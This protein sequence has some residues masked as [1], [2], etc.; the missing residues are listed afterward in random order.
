MS[1]TISRRE[2]LHD[3]LA[4]GLVLGAGWPALAQGE[5]LIPFTDLPTPGPNA[6]VPPNL[7]NYFTDNDAFFA[8]QHY[9][10]PPPIDPATYKLRITGLVERPMELTLATLK[11]RPRVDEVVAFECSGNNNARGNPLLGNARWGGTSV[12]QL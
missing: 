11:A 8:V 12:A 9:P 5:E 2:M 3:L 1:A 4:A 10:V 6:R 7:L